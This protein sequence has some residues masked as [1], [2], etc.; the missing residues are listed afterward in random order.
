MK[1]KSGPWDGRMFELGMRS[2]ILDVYDYFFKFINGELNQ[3]RIA[4]CKTFNAKS[5]GFKIFIKSDWYQLPAMVWKCT[6]IR[7]LQREP[8][9][10]G[11]K[12]WWTVVVFGWNKLGLAF[13]IGEYLV[14]FYMN[15]TELLTEGE[16]DNLS[17]TNFI[18]QTKQKV[19]LL[20]VSDGRTLRDMLCNTDNSEQQLLRVLIQN[21]WIGEMRSIQMSW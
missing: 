1:S 16:N 15:N 13:E 20:S 10:S 3:N 5:V 8:L 2:W 7:N 12:I 19:L 14:P 17:L 4:L 6:S 21:G 9:G 11:K 18:N